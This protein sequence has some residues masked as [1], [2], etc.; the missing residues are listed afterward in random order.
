MNDSAG[1]TAKHVAREKHVVAR[2]VGAEI[3]ENQG[4]TG[5]VWYRCTVEQPLVSWPGH[6][7]CG[8]GKRYRI[9]YITSLADGLTDKHG[10]GVAAETLA[11]RAG[12]INRSD[13]SLG[14]STVV[15]AHLINLTVEE[16]RAVTGGH[17]ANGCSATVRSD[18]C[19]GAGPS[20]STVHV[21]PTVDAVPGERHM[22][23]LI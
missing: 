22:A 3:A 21:K 13:L 5:G 7:H 2:L 23:P 14:K 20:E 15:E 8:T 4:G 10:R 16:A 9:Y 19:V 6:A 12:G 18:R 1:G 11:V 17:C